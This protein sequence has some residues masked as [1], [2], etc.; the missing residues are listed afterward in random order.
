MKL[1]LFGLTALFLLDATAARAD[2]AIA[3][4][5]PCAGCHST[6]AGVN[7]QGPSLRGVIGRKAGSLAG[8]TYSPAMKAFGKSWDA[9]LL[10]SFLFN[11]AGTVPGTTM[12]GPGLRDENDRAELIAYL[13]TL[14]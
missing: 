10:D 13:A 9:A 4:F 14:K 6:E 3:L 11:P 2:D 12:A 5:K 7:K 8:F 1:S